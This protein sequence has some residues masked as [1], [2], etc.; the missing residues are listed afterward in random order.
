MGG[1]TEGYDASHFMRTYF[2][3]ILRCSDGSYYTGVTNDVDAR[4]EQHAQGEDP[5]S[6]THDRRPIKLVYCAEFSEIGDAIAWE[7]KVKRWTRVK[8]EALIR[9]EYE[10]LPGLSVCMNPTH[11]LYYRAI[12]RY[13]GHNRNVMHALLSFS[14]PSTTLRMTPWRRLV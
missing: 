8:K 11:Y 10:R 4:V 1:V 12:L 5:K 13:V 2:V 3:Y 14:H 9:G 7:K 6:Y